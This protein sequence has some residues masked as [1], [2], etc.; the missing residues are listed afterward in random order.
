MMKKNYLDINVAFA[1]NFKPSDIKKDRQYLKNI[2]RESFIKEGHEP[3][4]FKK[5]GDPFKILDIKNEINK[6]SLI[7]NVV[8]NFV[9]EIN[10]ASKSSDGTLF[11]SED[12]GINISDKKDLVKGINQTF[13]DESESIKDL[14]NTYD[15]NEENSG[16]YTTYEFEEELW[17]KSNLYSEAI[18]KMASDIKSNIKI[19][20]KIKKQYKNDEKKLKIIEEFVDKL[21]VMM[22][23]YLRYG[24]CFLSFENTDPN[25]ELSLDGDK[26]MN[27]LEAMEM[28]EEDIL[29][30][31]VSEARLKSLENFRLRVLTPFESYPIYLLNDMIKTDF[32]ERRFKRYKNWGWLQNDPMDIFYLYRV[33]NEVFDYTHIPVVAK[34]RVNNT[35][36]KNAFRGGDAPI[37]S[38]FLNTIQIIGLIDRIMVNTIPLTN[39]LVVKDP[40]ENLNRLGMGSDTES[41]T[42]AIARGFEESNNTGSPPLMTTSTS[43][44]VR[45]ENM[46][47]EHLLSVRNQYVNEFAR[48]TGQPPVGKDANSMEQKNDDLLDEITNNVVFHTFKKFTL[49]LKDVYKIDIDQNSLESITASA[50]INKNNEKAIKSTASIIKTAYM[51]LLDKGVITP[52]AFLEASLGLVGVDP[53]EDVVRGLMK[54]SPAELK[55]NY[56]KALKDSSTSSGGSGN[57]KTG[58]ISRSG[59]EDN[60][61]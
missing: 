45:V 58:S 22:V 59:T 7:H 15:L 16:G 44:E 8:N 46:N 12:S 4:T 48:A 30:G 55:T 20:S 6:Q 19:S 1:T 39:I 42:E 17:A 23:S 54:I 35:R 18:I 43:S 34:N 61:D 24:K 33:R 29:K 13:K 5:E 26:T 27:Y 2:A 41:T 9:K 28:I 11:D 3:Y 38:R 10:I 37:L 56:Q 25:R 32:T 53:S 52:E 50:I 51:P 47:F 31:K 40:S 14:A 36:E 49:V 21:E 60:L 57:K